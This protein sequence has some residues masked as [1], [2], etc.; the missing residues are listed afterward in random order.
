M[1]ERFKKLYELQHN[2]YSDNSAI[3]VNSGVLLND[4][5]TGS[6]IA[7]LKFHSLSE[8]PIVALKISISAFDIEGNKLEGV[9]DY[10]Y[11]DLKVLNGN[12]FG[13]NKAIIMPN[14]NTRSFQIS[15]ITIIKSNGVVDVVE[16]PLMP[17]PKS[18]LLSTSFK[19]QEEIKQYKIETTKNSEYIPQNKNDLWCCSCGEWNILKTCS[20]CKI[21][22]ED[23]FKYLDIALLE[24][25][26]KSRLINENEQKEKEIKDAKLKKKIKIAIILSAILLMISIISIVIYRSQHKYD[27]IAGIYALTNLEDAEEA[28]YKYHKDS[29]DEFGFNPYS[30]ELEIKG[31]GKVYGLWFVN[32][33]GTMTPRAAT[34][35]SVSDTGVVVF[36]IL[37]YPNENVT[38]TINLETG[39]AIYSS[40]GLTLKYRQISEELANN[41]YQ[42]YSKEEVNNEISF[43]QDLFKLKTIEAICNKYPS[44]TIQD[45]MFDVKIDGTF[46]GAMGTYEIWLDDGWRVFFAQ[47]LYDTN[48]EKQNLIDNLSSIFGE[49][50]YYESLDV[51]SWKDQSYNLEIDYYP[52]KG[53]YFYLDEQV[54]DSNGSNEDNGDISNDENITEESFIL[55]G[56]FTFHP[57]SFVMRFDDVDK[58]ASGYNYTYMRMNGESSLFYE[59]AEISG[60]YNNVR[61]VGMISFVKNIDTTMLLEED[62]TENIITKINVLVEDED[63]VPPIL[64]N[65]MCA[66]DPTLNFTTAYNLSFEVGEKAGTLDGYSYNGINY[67]IYAD[68]EYYY[69]IISV[70][71]ENSNVEQKTECDILGHLWEDAT[72]TIPMTCSRCSITSGKALGHDW[73][74]PTC[75]TP[76]SCCTCFEVDPNSKPLGHSFINGECTICGVSEEKD[77]IENQPTENILF[78]EITDIYLDGT[79]VD[80]YFWVYPS[81]IKAILDYDIKDESI[82]EIQRCGWGGNTSQLLFIPLATGETTVTVYIEGYEGCSIDV[83]IY[84]NVENGVS[85]KFDPE[86]PFITSTESEF[87]LKN[88]SAVTYIT[89]WNMEGKGEYYLT[90]DILI[91]SDV[92]ECVWGEWDGDSI[93][94]TFT[95]LSSGNAFVT[96]YINGYYENS[97][98]TIPV[99]V[100]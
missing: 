19:N 99:F 47:E 34:V 25:K 72:C 45:A 73:G 23:V 16:L 97:A 11:L 85:S 76:R 3:I 80:V 42:E 43:I 81:D 82:V 88:G 48:T 75:T 100:P 64:V 32:N 57:R 37:D 74:N 91:G 30:F 78:A 89:V 83:N 14:V 15:N 20:K 5:E 1:Q 95:P 50:K 51:Y 33:R 13:S 24:P 40:R 92:V 77:P 53:I 8:T 28:L 35:R 59:I 9:N 63:D 21:S 93:S 94:L 10:Q 38:F 62:Y 29:I 86:G 39:E 79:S 98:I 58:N 56:K 27:E 44:A 67:I 52:H 66:V 90:Y 96:I 41:G 12:D 49:Y 17:L 70:E 4:M 65:C 69:I 87:N 68:L 22:K 84:A 60:G 55:N 6:I 71:D 61:S 46:C 31:S 54:D 18:L 36:D 2:L 7:Q 26:I